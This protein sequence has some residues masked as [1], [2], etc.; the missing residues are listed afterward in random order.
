M[1]KIAF[2][3]D[4]P[5]LTSDHLLEKQIINICNRYAVK[6]NFAV[7]PF[8][9][10]DNKLHPL[11]QQ[12]ADH[13]INAEKN[14]WIEISQHGYAHINHNKDGIPSEFSD[15]STKV[16]SDLLAK[17]KSIL[18]QLFLNQRRGFVP[19]WNTFNKTT[20]KVV[21][22]KDFLF[23][24]AG[25]EIPSQ[26]NHLVP[27]LPRTCQITSLT[28][29]IT[30]TEPFSSLNPIII[31]VMHHYDFIESNKEQGSLSLDMFENCI[32]N[33]TTHDNVV[34]T[35]LNDLAKEQSISSSSTAFLLHSKISNIHWRLANYTP[36]NCLINCSLFK[37]YATIIK[38]IF[39]KLKL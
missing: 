14:S 20:S 9:K 29:C 39:F 37:L 8:K 6:I 1:I 22:A 18:D 28:D 3:F 35:S 2:R 12:K 25:W 7:I 27:L 33:L 26:T 16:Q 30:Q 31:V 23:L 13:L 17:G 10:I 5:S 38:N 15:E 19:P 32:K 11:T 4:D 24:S 34:L 21:S 36:N